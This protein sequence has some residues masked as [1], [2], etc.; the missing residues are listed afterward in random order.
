M[1][2]TLLTI[3]EM[4]LMGVGQSMRELMGETGMAGRSGN[5]VININ[6]NF[7]DDDNIKD[8][9]GRGLHTIRHTNPKIDDKVEVKVGEGLEFDTDDSVKVN[10]GEGLK[11]KDG[12]VVVNT[13]EG[14]KIKD[15]KVVANTHYGDMIGDGLKID[16][17]KKIAVKAGNG[18][19]T[20]DGKVNVEVGDGLKIDDNGKVALSVGDGVKVVDGKIVTDKLALGDGLAYDNQDRL[21][22]DNTIPG[23]SEMFSAVTDVK[24]NFEL[25]VLTLTKIITIFTVARS[26]VG[27]VVSVN[28]LSNRLEYESVTIGGGPYGYGASMQS[29][30]DRVIDVKT[31]SFYKK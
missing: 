7:D 13:G 26:K 8:L 5:K 24:L 17:N 12:K 29:V 21:I 16:D 27:T 11:I 22:I 30:P 9:L 2:F 23:P 28:P 10:T 3:L 19:E 14:L 25:G 1:L 4:V 18:L 20:A 6:L 31:P 15:G